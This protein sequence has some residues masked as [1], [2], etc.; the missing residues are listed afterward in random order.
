MIV[1][2]N[3]CSSIL[4]VTAKGE[5]VFPTYFHSAGTYGGLYTLLKSE[6]S[7][8]A[9]ELRL[10]RPLTPSYSGV[11]FTMTA[12]GTARKE[13]PAM[14]FSVTKSALLNELSTTLC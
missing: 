8:A 6:Y 9:V 5:V 1:V 4:S 14:E 3:Y 2:V 12:P 7:T 10:R 11:N 13:Y